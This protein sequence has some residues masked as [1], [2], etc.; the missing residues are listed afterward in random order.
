VAKRSGKFGTL[1]AAVDAAG[2]G[3]ILANDGP[4]TVL[5]PTD[6]AFAALPKGTVKSLLK[7]E[8]RD[9]LR[10]ILALHA[11]KGKVSAGDALNAGTAKSV[12]G[13]SLNFSIKEGTFRVNAATILETDINCDNG[14]IH[15][16]DKVLLPKEK[17]DDAKKS[18]SAPSPVERIEAAIDR[19][20][21]VFNEGDH[22]KCAAIYRECLVNLSEDEALRSDVREALSEL[23]KHADERDPTAKAWLLRHGMDRLYAGLAH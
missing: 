20:V 12:N 3:D 1:L 23:V 4:V 10:E 15:V 22:E 7:E 21:P 14:V 18:A 5:A 11:I 19:G 17:K 2:L 13:G 16:I 6:K 8:N 9:Q